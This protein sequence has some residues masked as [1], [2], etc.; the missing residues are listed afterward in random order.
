M[1]ESTGMT[2]MPSVLLLG[3][4]P[5]VVDFSAVPGLT[6]ETLARGLAAQEQALRE[7]GF[8]ARWCLVDL[9][10]T[11]E[12][13]ARAALEARSPEVVL[14]GA[15]VRT[16]PAHFLLFERLINLVHSFAPRARICFNTT[17]GDTVQ[18]VL[19]WIAVPDASA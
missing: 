19:R 3:L 10:E 9:G 6:A 18:A 16:I 12:A 11:A 15:G 5:E 13:V 4:L 17:P 2:R 14:I 1:T 7:L 8:D